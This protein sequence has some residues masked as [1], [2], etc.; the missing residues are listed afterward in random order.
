M[1]L[2]PS[3]MTSD[4][5]PPDTSPSRDAAPDRSTDDG[6]EGSVREKLEETRIDEQKRQSL[7]LNEADMKE[8]PGSSDGRGRLR[9]KRSLDDIDEDESKG[10]TK[11]TRKRSR[12]LDD[13]QRP[14]KKEK[15]DVEAAK[16]REVPST[17]EKVPPTSDAKPK[18]TQPI[19]EPTDTINASETATKQ[20]DAKQE[21][22]E[23]ATP[24]K[25]PPSSG[26][27]NAAGKSPFASL[28]TTKSPF[29]GSETSTN[30]SGFA[31][32]GFSSFAK[33]SASPF[34]GLSPTKEASEQKTQPA[35]APNE[36][37]S[38]GSAASQPSGFGTF[39]VQKKS[40]F[41][42]ALGSASPFASATS[43]SSASPLKTF[44]SSANGASSNG[45]SAVKASKLGEAS[46]EDDEAEEDGDADEA[47][48]QV[49][50]QTEEKTDE[51][52]YK[53]EVETGEEGEETVFQHRAKLYYK[54]GDQWKERGVGV[55][56]VNCKKIKAN[57]QEKT[58]SNGENEEN[59]DIE[60][61]APSGKKVL[62]RFVFRT[63]GNLRTMLNSPVTKD[64]TFTD[65]PGSEG[66][67]SKIFTGY[68]DG[69]PTPCL[70]Q[71][72]P[73]R[74]HDIIII[75]KKRW[76]ADDEAH[77]MKLPSVIQELAQVVDMIKGNL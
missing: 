2:T 26:F 60:A 24:S 42:G 8:V 50:T 67:K 19:E 76:R 36:K 7:E 69:K 12:E 32:S 20:L 29:R 3:P 28:D 25:I 11:H 63:D 77:Q 1:P 38:F 13:K 21:V 61:P 55:F 47:L 23:P 39:G 75:G 5:T 72:S 30:G 56:K 33:S 58:S 9:K 45:F 51:R 31:S 71:V 48:H 10:D 57:V 74:P 64:V 59:V 22:A 35:E 18:E 17:S 41:G 65:R 40:T 68:V 66:G 6:R 43:T 14:A 46:A 15:A 70:I 53:Q 73:P 27:A 49:G 54:P 34:G 52:F 16:E 62:A 37:L 4:T 44:A